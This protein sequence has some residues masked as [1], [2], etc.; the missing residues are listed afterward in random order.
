MRI[1]T[2]GSIANDHLMS[3]DGQF[4][5]QIRADSLEHLSVSFLVNEL[6]IH[7]GGT[8][9]NISYAAGLLGARPALVG[10]VGSDFEGDGR[11]WLEDHGVDTRFVSVSASR[12][13]A[14]FVCTTD[15]TGAQIGS[16]YPGAMAEAAGISLAPV[17]AALGGCDA[18]LVGPDDPTAMLAH[19]DECRA[20]GWPLWADVGQQV[21]RF[22]AADLTAFVDGATYLFTNTFEAGVLE[23]K[24]GWSTA[25]VLARVGTW[26]VTRGSESVEIRTAAAAP[27]VIPVVP[28]VNAVDP[29]GA[30]DAF[31]GGFLAAH[32][33]GLSDERAAQVGAAVAA[34]S[35]EAPGP[36][37]YTVTIEGVVQKI[38]SVYGEDSASEV[39]AASRS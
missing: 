13:T 32:G 25:E 30:G 15:S 6:N 36:Q 4:A 28:V 18:V 21:A 8:G 16:F 39:A 17:V 24:T 33:W 3:F 5:E 27:L 14:R 23:H 7:R 26:V 2:T 19:A 10:A 38:R 20:A 12:H 37:E 34:F 31:R 35:V 1:I 11:A 22:E 9:A 29:T